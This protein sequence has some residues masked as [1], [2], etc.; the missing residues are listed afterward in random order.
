MIIHGRIQKSK[1]RKVPKAVQAQNEQWLQD[2][3]KMTT[4]F[5]KKSVKAPVKPF[6]FTQTVF[7][8]ETPYIPSK[9]SDNMAPCVKPADKV[10]TGD[11]MLGIGT[12]HKSN[13]VPVFRVED[14]HDMAKMRR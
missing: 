14:A 4:N 10:Y 13:A 11:K 1:K 7:R 8:R 9:N 5:S 12:L 6:S 3:Q 2:L